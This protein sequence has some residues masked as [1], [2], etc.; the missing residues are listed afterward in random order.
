LKHHTENCNHATSSDADPPATQQ[1]PSSGGRG[2]HW[3]PAQLAVGLNV[4]STQSPSSTSSQTA[5][6]EV[7]MQQDPCK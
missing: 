4:P 3:V 2:R 1:A 7:L 5:D 6:D